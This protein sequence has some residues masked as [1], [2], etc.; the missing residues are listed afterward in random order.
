MRKNQIIIK[1]SL[2]YKYLLL[3][4]LLAG[5]CLGTG[6]QA[7]A[8]I[9]LP[10]LIS[11]HMVL[12]QQSAVVLWGWASKGEWITVKASWLQKDIRTQAN[13][14]GS[15][16]VTV[17]TIQAGGPY[18]ISF[19]G[20]TAI[21]VNNVLL[22][23]VWLASGQ[24]NMEFYMDKGEGW[25][26]GVINYPEEIAQANYPGIRMI[27]VPNTVA[28]TPRHDF[29]GSWKICTP[30]DAGS[31]SAVAYYFA[32]KVHQ[33]TGFPV[34]II[35]ATWG[36]T[37]AESWTRKEVLQH[38]FTSILTRYQ[39]VCDEYPENYKKFQ[40]KL[41]TWKADTSRTK[42]GAP[43]EPIGPGHNK[44]PYKL[45]NGMI[46]PLL[47]FTFRGVIWYQGE[48]NAERAW[49]YR[50][51]FPA[52]I[53]DW[54]QQFHH[55]AMPFY[56]VQIAP[57]KGQNPVIR[58]AQLYALQQV[59]HT[60]MVVTTDVGDENDIHPRNKK[61][62]GERLALWALHYDYGRKGLETSGPLY[63]SYKKTG[64]R[65][66]VSFSHAQGLVLK[67]DTAAEWEIAGE[68]QQFKPAQ[69]RIKGTT[70]EVWSDLVKA[71][72]AVRFAWKKAPAPNLFNK[73]GLPA[74]PFRTDT[75]PVETQDKD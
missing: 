66:V 59:S 55:P 1:Q 17:K 69:A 62:V 36:G 22:G 20:S 19:R 40:A 34:G 52:M 10:S 5:T 60:G 48:S 30:A 31:F 41:E 49:Q 25:R 44:S 38:D 27:E 12:Q 6:F 71:P 11:D 8:A 56:F 13:A 67:G 4:L 65:I 16:Q 72:A 58:E 24:S 23:E 45:Y 28:D 75:W 47:P 15:W 3:P 35:N 43:K 21:T 33:E 57:H 39:K 54:R 32:R 2:L 37:P 70:V 50:S 29:E 53:A 42:K 68:D 9:K 46:A 64:T 14:E 51:L 74:S 61:T 73:E 18:T 7:I 26:T 63:K